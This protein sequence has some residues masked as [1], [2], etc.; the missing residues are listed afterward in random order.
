MRNGLAIAI[1]P[2]RAGGSASEGIELELASGSL[3]SRAASIPHQQAKYRRRSDG[4]LVI[5]VET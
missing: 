4:R 2:H 3:S 1:R 5:G